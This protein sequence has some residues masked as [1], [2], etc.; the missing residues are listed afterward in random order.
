MINGDRVVVLKPDGT[1]LGETWATITSD[2]IVIRNVAPQIE[3]G[4]TIVRKVDGAPAESYRVVE[5]VYYAGTG[6]HFQLKVEK[7]TS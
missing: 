4:D 2:L 3:E 6:A 5:A 7:L 1:V